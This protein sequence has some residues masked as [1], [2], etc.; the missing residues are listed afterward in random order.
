ML[1]DFTSECDAPRKK[2][3]NQ[4]ILSEVVEDQRRYDAYVIEVLGEYAEQSEQFRKRSKSTK[5]PP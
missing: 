2:R 5:N 4:D 3:D 1:A